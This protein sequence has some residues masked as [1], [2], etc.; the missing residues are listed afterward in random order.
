MLR[1]GFAWVAMALAPMALAADEVEEAPEFLLGDYGVRVD[2]SSKWNMTRWSDWDLKAETRD[3]LL[4][5]AWGTPYQSD[6]GEVDP[7]AWESVFTDRI[8][9]E[10]GGAKEAKLTSAKVETVGGRE[11]VLSDFDLVLN[12]GTKAV[13]RGATLAIEGQMFHLAVVSVSRFKS[14]ADRARTEL[15]DD[16]DVRSDAEALEFGVA[17]EGDG[18]Q[19]TLPDGWRKPLKQEESGATARVSKL[20]LESLDDCWLG[21]SVDGPGEAS[22]LVACQGGLQLGVVDTYSFE[23]VEPTVRKR[24]MGSDS[25]A[26]A[27]M[28]ELS[29]RVG[30]L[31]DLTDKGLAVGVV[32]FENGVV[33]I[34]GVGENGEDGLAE[35][36]QA[37][38]IGGTYEGQHP[39]S[40]GD[41]VNYYISY[42]PM[43]PVVL[44]PAGLGVLLL[45]GLGVGGFMLASRRKSPYDL[46]DEDEI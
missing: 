46:D 31:Y 41:R 36:V 29:D 19:H 43:S 38:M 5:Q 33:R 1:T 30:F 35:A 4:M 10:M 42:R 20:G 22:A 21:L 27:R 16:L 18:F 37:T 6:V 14:K 32:P 8:D 26:P 7:K 12:S 28:V 13:L 17:M 39:A 25:I 40:V 3:P 15:L 23:G 44:L 45:G 9:E 11:V 2:L 34:W 24:V